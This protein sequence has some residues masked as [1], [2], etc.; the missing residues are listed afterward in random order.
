MRKTNIVFIVLLLAAAILA[1]SAYFLFP[2]LDEFGLR[3]I[4]AITVFSTFMFLSAAWYFLSSLKSFKV[5]LK[6]AYYLLAAGI[7][8]YSLVLAQLFITLFIDLENQLILRNAMFLVPYGLASFL[9]YLGMRKFARLLDV[10]SIWTSFLFVLLAASVAAGLATFLPIPSDLLAVVDEMTIDII[11]ATLVWCTVFATM[12]AIVA[13]QVRQ[14]I[15]PTYK[16]AMG[17]TIAA[18][19][20]LA[21][22]AVHE[23]VVKVY[24][25]LTDYAA[26]D[27]APLLF[28]LTGVAF[29]RAGLAFNE[30]QQRTLQLPPNATPVDIVVATASLVSKPKVVDTELDKLRSIT[31]KSPNTQLTTQDT[32]TLTDVYLYLEDYLVNHEP[33]SKFSREG[34]RESL[35]ES[36]VTSLK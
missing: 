9:A 7:V 21:L 18:L 28:V 32:K 24:F 8:L 2:S 11:M 30:T 25:S 31:A 22:S 20:I 12:A 10:K 36:F 15:S 1:T 26:S 23:L 4:L 3:G 29:L 14:A 27:Y 33:L 13:A 35:P 6:V 34:L 16:S 19:V 17:W 5:G